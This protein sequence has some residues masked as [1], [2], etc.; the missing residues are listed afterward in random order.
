MGAAG[1]IEDG[2]RFA[3][4]RNWSRF[5]SKLTPPR[6][7]AARQSLVSWLGTDNLAGRSFI[8]VGSGS[9]VFSLA[10]RSLGARVTSFDY[11]P[12]S[13]ACA[14]HLK[15]SHFPGSA[16]WTIETGSVLDLNY[17]ATLGRHDIVYSWGV[18][19]HTGAMHAAL[20]NVVALVKPQG[21]LFIAIYND[22]AW[23]SQYWVAVKRLYNRHAVGRWLMIAVHAPY[24]FGLRYLV[25]QFRRGTS[26]ERG[27]SLWY[28]MLDWLG[29]YPFEVAK[30]EDIVAFYRDRGFELERLRTCYG[31]HGCNEFLF[32]HK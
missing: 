7:E 19:H 26:V 12:D 15:A 28:D 17:L 3:F 18:L 20:H 24:L 1:E 11:D 2:Q 25:R 30:P 8:D 29:G 9:G 5:L 14:I 22:Q 13:V 27:M 23:I 6:V 31:R 10:A 32:R 21:Q 16:E 4:G